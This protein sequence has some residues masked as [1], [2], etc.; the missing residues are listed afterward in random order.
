[1][2]DAAEAK[3]QKVDVWAIDCGETDDTVVA[4]WNKHAY[5]MV[6]LRDASFAVAEEYGMQVV[7]HTVLLQGGKIRA[8]LAGPHEEMET[9]VQ[10]EVKRL[11]ELS[12]E[13]GEEETETE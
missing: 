8:V 3:G 10:E 6:C 13:A 9:L 11:L 5:E 4:Y 1:M 7:P 2:R 12:A